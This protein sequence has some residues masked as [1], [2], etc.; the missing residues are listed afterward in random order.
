MPKDHTKAEYIEVLEAKNTRLSKL[1]DIAEA[2]KIHLKK[3]IE[4]L[5]KAV[6]ELMKKNS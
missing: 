2:Q 5:Q 1:L 4:S 6:S 3:R